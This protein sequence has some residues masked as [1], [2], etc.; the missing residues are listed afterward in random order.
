MKRRFTAFILMLAVLLFGCG[1]ETQEESIAP[2]EPDSTEPEAESGDS[3]PE[4]LDFGGAEVRFHAGLWYTSKNPENEYYVEEEN[5]DIVND[6][7]YYRNQRVEDRLNVKLTFDLR[8]TVWA[9]RQEELNYITQSVM[10]GDDAFDIAAYIAHLM[11]SIAVGGTMHNLNDMK[12]LDFSAPWWASGYNDVSEINGRLYF[13]VGDVVMG[14][15]GATY[16]MFFNQNL[17]DQLKLEDPYTLVENG[18]WTLDKLRELTE[19]GYGDLN[20]DTKADENDRLGL[21]IQGGNHISGFMEACNIGILQLDSDGRGGEY[22]FGS[23]H[24][25]EVVE[26]LVRLI[27]ETE[28]AF[29]TSEAA[30]NEYLFF[31][32]NTVF[33]GGWIS[34]TDYYRELEFDFGILPY[35]KFDE[36]QESYF[37]R[38]GTS[39]P[40]VTIPVT[41]RNTDMASAVLEAMAS[42]GYYTVRPAYFDTALKEKY[43]RDEKTK[44]MIDLIIDGICV[45]FG[46]IYV[47]SLNDI[48]DQFKNT[49][50]RNDANWASN[51]KSWESGVMTSLEALLAV[52]NE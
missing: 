32:G 12:Y 25:T 6:A 46:T 51:T 19:A 4:G 26:K 1:S 30:A 41:C 39:C 35:P 3:L 24:N 40:V 17:I 38:V 31:G 20:G 43:S 13:A 36:Q 16:S 8:P 29:Y 23:S 7:V 37:S 50:S 42:E 33:T 10:A 14:M 2:A 28:G 27:H 34:D 21:V 44:E 22:I 52:I 15:Y 49:I 47:Y 11:P 5:G 48:S 9:S 45:D 18:S